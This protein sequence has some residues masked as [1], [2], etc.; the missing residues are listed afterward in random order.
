MNPYTHYRTQSLE[1][2]SPVRLVVMAFDAALVACERHDLARSTQVVGT[3]RDSLNFDEQEAA[4]GFYRLYQWVLDCIRAGDWAAAIKTLRELR[5][6]WAEIE[7][8]QNP[9]RSSIA[10]TALV[11]QG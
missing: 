6:A 2:A 9:V 7:R 1:G 5:T 3:L 10:A 4:V 8:R 11:M